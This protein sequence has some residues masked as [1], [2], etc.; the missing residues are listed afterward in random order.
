MTQEAAVPAS[1]WGRIQKMIDDSIAKYARSGPLRNA[2]ITGGAGL[3]I[4]DGGAF[5]ARY[6]EDLG[7]G[8][9]FYVGPLYSATD[10]S[11]VGTGML[12]QAPDGTDLMVARTDTTFGTT[13]QNFY[14][15][16]GRIIVGNDASS[17]QG[18]A[19]PYMPGA[20]YPNRYADMTVSS[21]STTWETVLV[22]SIPKHNPKLQVGLRATTDTSGATGEVRVLVN[23]TQLGAVQEVTYAV[24]VYD[25]TAAV[26]GDHMT[27]LNVEVQ[28]QRTGTVAGGVR[29]AGVYMQGRQS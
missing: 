23:G 24:S 15:S 7:G 20:L 10:G 25:I 2:S 18:L 4:A 17:G 9:A 21:T 13:M 28:A 6:P 26:A 22:G 16:G 8:D 12:L 27:A 19:R 5:R 29:V 14:D 3:T 1:L 11:Y